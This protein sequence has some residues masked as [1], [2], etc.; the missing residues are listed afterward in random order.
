MPE[1][2][3]VSIA[4]KS[5]K[6]I[7]VVIIIRSLGLIIFVF[8]LRASRYL[9][10]V[11]EY[12]GVIVVGAYSA[13]AVDALVWLFKLLDCL[14]PPEL[15]TVAQCRLAEQQHFGVLAMSKPPLRVLMALA[16][17]VGEVHALAK[18]LAGSWSLWWSNPHALQ[19]DSNEVEQGAP[20]EQESSIPDITEGFHRLSLTFPLDLEDLDTMS[21]E[22]YLVLRRILDIAFDDLVLRTLWVNERDEKIERVV[23]VVDWMH[24]RL[25]V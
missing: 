1:I 25:P 15:L 3:I 5:A 7:V 14:W 13:Y 10:S 20:M 8:N 2:Y 6:V 17:H 23:D 9:D 16:E 12:Q 19:K 4:A 24:L 22:V 11:W 21:R 18:H